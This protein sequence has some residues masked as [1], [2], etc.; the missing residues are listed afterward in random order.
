MSDIL[1]VIEDIKGLVRTCGFNERTKLSSKQKS[2]WVKRLA[3]ILNKEKAAKE[4]LITDDIGNIFSTVDDRLLLFFKKIY[5]TDSKYRNSDIQRFYD[6]YIRTRLAEETP[7]NVVVK[8]EIDVKNLSNKKFIKKFSSLLKNDKLDEDVIDKLT[9]SKVSF[10]NKQLL[11]LYYIVKGIPK[12][13][14]FKIPILETL[15]TSRLGINKKCKKEH[16]EPIDLTFPVDKNNSTVDYIHCIPEDINLINLSKS[17]NFDIRVTYKIYC[18]YCEDELVEIFGVNT[19]PGYESCITF[20]DLGNPNKSLMVPSSGIH[21]DSMEI[22]DSYS[23]A[24]I[25]FKYNSSSLKVYDDQYL[26]FLLKVKTGKLK[27]TR[28]VSKNNF[29]NSTIQKKSIYIN[30]DPDKESN[31]LVSWNS[32]E[33]GLK[34]I[35][36]SNPNYLIRHVMKTYEKMQ[37]SFFRRFSIQMRNLFNIDEVG[38]SVIDL[39]GEE[40]RDYGPRK[41]NEEV[42][43]Y[44]NKN[45]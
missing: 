9:N 14:D 31:V 35:I 10:S 13:R 42:V 7:K 20:T 39:L 12:G 25:T 23:R 33:K 11:K 27:I 5:I 3:V 28:T 2:L 29:F 22:N 21:F 32:L 4:V 16:P 40:S 44:L 17:S 18:E 30:L 1:S 6:N 19:K 37:D 43:K 34:T 15:L 41:M 8:K 38:F 24:R 36:H 45:N 26:G